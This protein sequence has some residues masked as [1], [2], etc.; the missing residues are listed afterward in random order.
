MGNLLVN[1]R[2]QQFVLFEQLKI[3]DLFQTEKFKDFTKDDLMMILN[4]AEKMAVEVIAP[5][6]KEGDQQGARFVDGRVY[7][8]DCYH[9]AYKTYCEAGWIAA[10]EDPEVGGQGIPA[11]VQFANMELFGAANYAFCM[12][13][14]LTHGAAGLIQNYGTEE[15]K[16]KYMYKLYT[17]EWTGTM[18]LTEPGAGSDVGALKTSAKR[19]PDGKFLIT[20]TKIFIS[21][22]DHD[23]TPN[24]V[25]PVLARIEGDPAGTR[26]ISIF[27]VPKYRVNDDGS[28]GE[29]N[30]VVT[31]GIEHKMG[32][33][34]SA[35]SDA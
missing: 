12:Y 8:P 33:K 35:T 16:N 10:A 17:G 27:I 5:T 9:T 19:L 15:Q 21:S 30:D 3:E 24:I 26:G 1:T 7:V 32:I 29:F 6:L 25:H 34:G 11:S 2:D 23:L 22:G 13:P 28:L 18:C 4:E 31:G 20:G 14:G